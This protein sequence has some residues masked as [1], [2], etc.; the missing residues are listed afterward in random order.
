MK[1]SIM[2]LFVILIPIIAMMFI[3]MGGGGSCTLAQPPAESTVP[4]TITVSGAGSAG[5]DGTY[6]RGSDIGL[7]P[8]WSNGT[9]TILWCSSCSIVFRG[10]LEDSTPKDTLGS[11]YPDAGLNDPPWPK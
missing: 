8:S 9:Y 1:R 2:W 11:R 7:M 4:D 10:V 3:A 5:V 6:S